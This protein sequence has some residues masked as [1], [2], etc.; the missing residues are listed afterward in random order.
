MSLLLNG[1]LH[2]TIPPRA[3]IHGLKPFR[4]WLRIRRENRVGNRQ[5]RL[6]PRFM[7]PRNPLPR[8]MRPR[9]PLPRFMRPRNPLPRFQ[10]D[11]GISSQNWHIWLP[12]LPRF[13]WDRGRRFWRLPTRISR[14]IR[15]HIRNGFCPWIRALGGIVIDEKKPRVENLV[16]LSLKSSQNKGFPYR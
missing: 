7:R 16:T 5:N 15:S 10:L 4:I 9:N 1:F 3:L 8:F 2:Q 13:I 11:L 14:R 12:Q 6:L